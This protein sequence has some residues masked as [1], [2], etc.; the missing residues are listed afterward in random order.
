M[1]VDRHHP[2]VTPPVSGLL[3]IRPNSRWKALG[4]GIA[5]L[6]L[7]TGCAFR[8]HRNTD[9]RAA[10]QRLAA[11]LD[12]M[13]GY[14]DPESQQLALT[15]LNRT[16]ELAR[17]YEVQTPPLWHNILVNMGLRERGLCC[18]W[19]EDLIESIRTL[20]LQKYSVHWGVSRRGTW[21]EH[22]SVVVTA[23]GK[24]FQTGLVLDPWREAGD[25]F[26]IPVAEDSYPWQLH[27]GDNGIARI[28]CR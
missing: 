24:S 4:I 8:G 25:L 26:W 2:S 11:D 3:S 5:L 17:I 18:H 15:V 16:A 19:T 20:P 9:G 12:Q 7:L 13:L 6:L 23:L 1:K 14:H 28:G 10:S 22:N 21:R 27:P